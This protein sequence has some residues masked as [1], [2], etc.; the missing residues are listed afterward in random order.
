MEKFQGLKKA[1]DLFLYSDSEPNEVMIGLCHAVALP[2][3][4]VTDIH[5][6]SYLFI[7]IAISAGVYQI[8][9]ALLSGSL[10][11]RLRSVQLASLIALLTVENLWSVGELNGSGIGWCI[12]LLM[13]IWNTIRVT[14]E[15]LARNKQ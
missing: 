1:R 11:H 2:C 5:N 8:W 4:L 15:K 12:I 9:S 14:K 6:S 10:T 13:A 7:C 3:T